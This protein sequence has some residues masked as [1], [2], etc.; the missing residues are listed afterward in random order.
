MAVCW[1]HDDETGRLQPAAATDPVHEAGLVSGLSADWYEYDVFRDGDVT[2]ALADHVTTA[3][4]RVDRDQEV[5]ESERRFRLI[6][7]RI[8][9][10]IYLAEPDFSEVLYVNPA[11]EEIWGQPTETLYSDATA[12][13]EAIDGRDREEFEADFEAMIADIQA[14]DPAVD[15]GFAPP[16]RRRPIQGT[17]AV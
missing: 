11:Y 17:I 9:E 3:L 8:D 1:F 5:R 7:E 13:L 6:A 2:K 10:V 14:G 16:G 15:A 12:F 4:D